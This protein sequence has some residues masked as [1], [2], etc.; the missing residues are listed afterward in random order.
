MPEQERNEEGLVVSAEIFPI[1]ESLRFVFDSK[2]TNTNRSLD[3]VPLNAGQQ[4][5]V[6]PGRV[7]V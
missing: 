3:Y 1:L 2:P 7:P 4:L 6:K 5:T